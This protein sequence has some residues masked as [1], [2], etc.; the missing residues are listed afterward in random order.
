MKIRK[1]IAPTVRQA[2]Q[3]IRNELGDEAVI[4]SNR[5]VNDG[6]VEIIA[7]SNETM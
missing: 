1:F 7:L 4:L 5:N 2:L 3:D 6:E